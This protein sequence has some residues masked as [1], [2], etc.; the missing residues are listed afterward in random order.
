VLL[1]LLLLRCQASKAKLLLLLRQRRRRRSRIWCL[2]VCS[3]S[4]DGYQCQV[5]LL[6]LL[7]VR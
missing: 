2:M 4:R 1:L 6:L 3:S 7:L 5:P